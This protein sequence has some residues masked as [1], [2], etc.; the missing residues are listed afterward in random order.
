MIGL[1]G[2]TCPMRPPPTPHD[3]ASGLLPMSVG[4]VSRYS[5]SSWERIVTLSPFCM[6][7]ISPG[8]AVTDLWLSDTV[9]F[10]RGSLSCRARPCFHRDLSRPVASGSYRHW[11]AVTLVEDVASEDVAVLAL[12]SVSAPRRQWQT[13][14]WSWTVQLGRR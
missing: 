13:C 11:P 2:P 14:E 7:M 1:T 12:A 10:L 9:I 5:T 3:Q 4:D 6:A 8:L